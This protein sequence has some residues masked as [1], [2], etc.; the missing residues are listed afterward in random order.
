MINRIP[1]CYKKEKG[2]IESHF[3]WGL[4]RTML[5]NY[6]P[7]SLFNALLF[8]VTMTI[9]HGHKK[10]GQGHESSYHRHIYNVV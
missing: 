2:K 9:G 8:A 3:L 7:C 5:F 6:C 1:F 10:L 4:T